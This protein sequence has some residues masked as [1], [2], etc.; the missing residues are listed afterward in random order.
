MGP[1]VYFCPI[2]C[3][4]RERSLCGI[5]LIFYEVCLFWNKVIT[6]ILDSK[7]CVGICATYIMMTQLYL[8]VND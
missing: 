7:L 4:K 8:S 6:N 1:Q 3:Q 2:I 5:F